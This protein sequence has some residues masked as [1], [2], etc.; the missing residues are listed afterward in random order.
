MTMTGTAVSRSQTCM[1]A[2]TSG[3]VHLET[4]WHDTPT[5]DMNGDQRGLAQSYLDMRC[6]I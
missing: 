4:D 1:P 2:L 3:C 6:Q 5:S